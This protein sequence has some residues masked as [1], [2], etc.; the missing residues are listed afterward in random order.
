MDLKIEGKVA[1]VAAASEGIG[2]AT[3][4]ILAQEGAKVSICGRNPEKLRGALSELGPSHLAIA[5][6]VSKKNDLENWI[7]ETREK[8]G[9]PDILVTNTGG[10]KPGKPSALTD[11]D[12]QNGFENTLLNVTRMM[13]LV[14]PYFQQKNWGR[15]VHITSLVAKTPSQIL[16]ISS[17]LRAGISALCRL[18]AKELGLYNVTV[19]AVLPGN[20]LTQRQ[21]HLLMLNAQ[22][23]HSSVDQEFEKVKKSIPLQRMAAPQEIGNVIAFLCSE[24]AGFVSGTVI[25]VDGASTEGLG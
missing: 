21:Q 6:D 1:L 7:R 22:R 17:T 5:A 14:V 4:K 3:A 20:T 16:T 9:T 24:L 23:N 2:F 15:V 12:W 11:E 13:E 10:P 25:P 19:N 8:L 18:Q